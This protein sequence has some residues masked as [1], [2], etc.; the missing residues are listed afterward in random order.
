MLAV[1]QNVR[2]VSHEGQVRSRSVVIL[3]RSAGAQLKLLVRA[4]AE[5]GYRLNFSWRFSADS[6]LIAPTQDFPTQAA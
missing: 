4:T 2:S 6:G 3:D 1:R 5:T